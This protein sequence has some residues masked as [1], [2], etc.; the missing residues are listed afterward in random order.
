MPAPAPVTETT[1]VTV[2]EAAPPDPSPANPPVED[3]PVDD[4]AGDDSEDD[5]P[6]EEEAVRLRNGRLSARSP[7]DYAGLFGRDDGLWKGLNG[8]PGDPGFRGGA[9]PPAATGYPVT[10]TVQQVVTL[11]GPP[12]V[13]V[14]KTLSAGPT[15]KRKAPQKK[16]PA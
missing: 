1:T 15:S 9:Q 11:Y 5:E 13:T 6:V 10:L 2:T 14:T 3:E 16:K 4:P 8:Y 7:I 12:T